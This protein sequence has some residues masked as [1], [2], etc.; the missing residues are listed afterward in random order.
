MFFQLFAVV[1][2]LPW[3]HRS[4]Y[5]KDVVEKTGT[6]PT[7]WYVA[8]IPETKYSSAEFVATIG[9]YSRDCPRSWTW[10]SR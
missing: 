6:S 3:I 4:N 2:L 8:I 10:D 9:L 5:Y 1:G 7:W